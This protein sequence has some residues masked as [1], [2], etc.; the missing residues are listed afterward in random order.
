MRI[1]FILGRPLYHPSLVPPQSLSKL[2][3]GSILRAH[4]KT[5]VSLYKWKTWLFINE[6]PGKHIK[7]QRHCFA[8]KSPSS[9]SYGFSSG[10]IWMWELDHKKGWESK[11]WCF[12]IVCQRRLFE[13][14]LNC[15]KIKPVNSKGNQPWVF[16]WRSDTKPLIL[17]P[18]NVKSGLIG[19]DPYA[20]KDWKQKE[21]RVAEDGMVR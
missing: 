3:E 13:G 1:I 19:K 4:I 16:I 5:R 20:R 2:N 12:W 21:K 18:P 14:P 9:Q 17:W 8:N 6:K 11:N 7:K 15:K 10:E